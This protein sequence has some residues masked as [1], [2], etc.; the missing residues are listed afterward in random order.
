MNIVVKTVRR[1]FRIISGRKG[2][3]CFYGKGN[4][5][6]R[7]VFL[8]ERSTVGS[9]NY[10]GRGTMMANAKVGNYCS[11]AP[12][13]KLGQMEHDMSCVSTSTQIFGPKHGITNFSGDKEP[14]VIED[15]VWL[16]ANVIVR[17]G[18]TVHTGAVVG[19]G[20]VVTKDIPPYAIAVGVPARVISYRFSATTIENIL[21]SKW[22]TL[23]PKQARELCGRLQRDVEKY[24]K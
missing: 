24:E 21:Q 5:F 11:I 9:Y 2:N 6:G 16:S 15:D 22:W 17:Q 23:P 19:A 18:V 13:V 1:L 20:A 8:H 3:Y 14:T 10:I 7:N 12:D 4:V